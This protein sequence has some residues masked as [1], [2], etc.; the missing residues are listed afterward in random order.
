LIAIFNEKQINNS[1]SPLPIKSKSP[2]LITKEQ[3]FIEFQNLCKHLKNKKPGQNKLLSQ[4][5]MENQLLPLAYKQ[6]YENLP[7]NR[8]FFIQASQNQIFS[9]RTGHAICVIMDEIYLFGGIDH[10]EVLLKKEK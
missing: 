2:T 5:F 8:W 3:S 9:P 4:N 1:K 7:N 6:D 10:K